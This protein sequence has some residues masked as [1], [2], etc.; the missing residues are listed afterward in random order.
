KSFLERDQMVPSM[1]YRTVTG[2]YPSDKTGNRSEKESRFVTLE[3]AYGPIYPC[4][5]A[6]VADF[7]N[8]AGHEFFAVCDYTVTLT[9]ALGEGDDRLGGLVFDRCGG[10]LCPQRERFRHTVST[11]EKLPLRSGYFI[12]K[13]RG[14]NKALI[15]WLHGA[16]EGGQDTAIA[17]AGNKVTALTEDYV[18]EMFGGAFVFV[19]Q[20]PTMWMDDGSG[21]YGRTGRSIYVEALKAAID[22]FIETYKDA[23]DPD[24]IYVGGDSNGG[25]MTMRML[26]DYPDFFAAA[27]PIC[28]AM[29]DECITEEHI[30][31][32]KE[33]PIW[34]THAINDPIVPPAEYA[35]P[36]YQ[37]LKAA[38]AGNVHFTCWDKIVDIHTGFKNE[39][40]EPYEYMGHF[41]WIPML[42]DDCR[43]DFDRKPVVV[44]NREV[45]LLQWLSLQ[46]K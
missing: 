12:P 10:V 42:N 7:S 5:S 16:G 6:L 22:E 1:G 46:R 43:L 20:C 18:Q 2:V 24:R 4:S 17:Y 28:E 21:E 33:I 36:T 30:R 15:V 27:F 11:F 29:L 35:I 13:L 23:I 37:R 25:F 31:R 38:G 26:M 40:G 8:I 3:L 19:P 39:K 9:E 44:D 34:F 14:G 32:M 41:S 45:T